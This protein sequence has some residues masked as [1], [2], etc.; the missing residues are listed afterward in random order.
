M[1]YLGTTLTQAFVRARSGC[2]TQ[3]CHNSPRWETGLESAND[4]THRKHEEDFGDFE[5]VRVELRPASEEDG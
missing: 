1:G 4:V 5:K 2:V 3:R